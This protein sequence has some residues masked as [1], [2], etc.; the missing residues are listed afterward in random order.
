MH[1]KYFCCISNVMAVTRK[2]LRLLRKFLDLE[3]NK[4]LFHI[5]F[6]LER[7]TKTN[8]GS[9]DDLFPERHFQLSFVKINIYKIC[10]MLK[11]DT[12]LQHNFLFW[13]N[14]YFS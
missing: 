3:I 8:Y 2:V 1:I 7:M 4:L 9:S 10:K 14:N 11:N 12:S 5:I 13:K 6:L